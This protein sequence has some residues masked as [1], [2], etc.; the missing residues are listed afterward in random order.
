MAR[1]YKQRPK[2]RRAP[3]RRSSGGISRGT[4]FGVG[5]CVGAIVT[6]L[7]FVNGAK[8]SVDELASGITGSKSKQGEQETR[9]EFYTVLPGKEVVVP[10][11]PPEPSAPVSTSTPQPRP[12][13]P[14]AVDDGRFMLQAGS[15]KKAA[16]ADSQKA[17]LALLGLEASVQ[18][19]NLGDSGTWHRVRLGPFAGRAASNEVKAMLESNGIKAMTTRLR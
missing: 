7:I 15:F 4:A 5:V 12:E 10:D 9:F 3:P 17:R 14:K 8:V 1:D 19:V 11:A 13:Q 18:S 16:D 6:A 2:Q